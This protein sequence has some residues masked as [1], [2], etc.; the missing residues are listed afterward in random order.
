MNLSGLE[1]QFP[2]ARIHALDY[3][4]RL[5]ALGAVLDDIHA[6]TAPGRRDTRRGADDRFIGVSE[7]VNEV[8]HLV[9]QVAPSQATVLINGESGTG[10]EVIARS[11]H[12][13]SGRDGP[14]VA[15]NC[16]AIPEHL[17]ESELFGHEKGAFTGAHAACP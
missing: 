3:P 10:K 14:F 4:V 15:V 12:E 8:R 9:A 16:G 2:W 1:R 6:A 5:D 11:N 7:S 13:L 17:L